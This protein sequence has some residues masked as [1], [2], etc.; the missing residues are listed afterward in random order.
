ML[1]SPSKEDKDDELG[2][3]CLLFFFLLRFFF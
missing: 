1:T 3:L 2:L